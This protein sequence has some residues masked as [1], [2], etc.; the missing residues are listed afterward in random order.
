MQA[1]RSR[2][3]GSACDLPSEMSA[4]RSAMASRKTSG[5]KAGSGEIAFSTY[6]EAPPR[7]TGVTTA[8]SAW[9]GNRL[10][11]SHE[12]KVSPLGAASPA[13]DSKA[14][15]AP[16]CMQ[17]TS[18]RLVTDQTRSRSAASL[19]RW[20][21][22]CAAAAR[23]GRFSCAVEAKLWTALDSEEARKSGKELRETPPADHPPEHANGAPPAGDAE[24]G[25]KQGKRRRHQA[26]LWREAM[27]HSSAASRAGR[28][29]AVARAAV[30]ANAYAWRR[31]WRSW[32]RG[33]ALRSIL[34]TPEI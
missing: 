34:E 11:L 27:I 33:Q 8:S 7:N 10:A 2:A 20:M 21:R 15:P 13:C 4:V 29:A 3:T 12:S 25:G 17:S 32:V 23:A 31:F 26:A 18:L 22:V 5:E 24:A 14:I 28:V 1:A 16:P 19:R 9:S 6:G 30:A